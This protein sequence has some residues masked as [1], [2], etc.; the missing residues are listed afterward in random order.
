MHEEL[1]AVEIPLKLNDTYT[2]TVLDMLIA[3]SYVV[4]AFAEFLADRD[5]EDTFPLKGIKCRFQDCSVIVGDSK[6]VV[7]AYETLR[8]YS[9]P[10]GNY[11]VFNELIKRAPTSTW[12][13]DLNF[14]LFEKW[15][16]NR[17]KATEDDDEEE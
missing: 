15:Y 16:S 4:R 10:L 7:A 14:R 11:E 8:R 12:K 9:I 2:E 6:K 17:P 1:I 13:L 5:E 3:P